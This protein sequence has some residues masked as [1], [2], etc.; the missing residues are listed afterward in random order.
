MTPAQQSWRFAYVLQSY[1]MLAHMAARGT[2]YSAD[3]VRAYQRWYNENI[4]K[5]Q[6]LY[7][8]LSEEQGTLSREVLQAVARG[9]APIAV[10][11]VWDD[12]IAFRTAVFA[13]RATPPSTP[14]LV[15]RWWSAREPEYAQK[16]DSYACVAGNI[17]SSTLVASR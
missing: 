9:L 2:T 5:T 4:E 12:R 10:N 8:T 1:R 3:V 15:A 14:S 16:I 7:T 17:S 11:G 6:S 13:V